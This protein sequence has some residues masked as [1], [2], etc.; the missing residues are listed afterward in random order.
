MIGLHDS[1]PARTDISRVPYLPGL[2]G[3]RALAV[4]AVMIYHANHEWLGGGFL[5]VE[6]F[7]VI[8]GYLITLLLVGEHERSGRIALKD[9]WFRRFRR[10]LPALFVMMSALAVYMSLFHRR[11]Q[12][13][14]RGDFLGGIFYGSNWYQIAVGQGYTA[15][16]A[17]APLRHLWSLAVEE[18]FYLVW[19][20]VMIL[21]LRRGARHLPRIG[22]WLF[23]VSVTIAIVTGALFGGGDVATTCAPGRMNGYWQIAGRC[24]STNESLYLSTITRAGGLMLGAAFAMVWRPGAIVRGP[25]RDKGRQVDLLAGAGVAILALL[26]W[27]LR[28]TTPGHDFG[29]R[30]DPWL[31]RGGFF[32]TGLAT[33]FI[34]AAAS[35]QRAATGTLLGNPVFV[36]IGTR[37]YGMYLYHWPIY[38]IIR[39]QAG[40]PLSIAQFVLAIAITVPITEAS[41]RYIETPIRKGRLSALYGRASRAASID[42]EARRNITIVLV[43]SLVLVGTAAISFAAADNVCVG[44]VACS[45]VGSAAD[46]T[47]TTAAPTQTTVPDVIDPTGT[48]T[49]VPPTAAPTTTVDLD[50]LPP[51]AIGESVMK[52]AEGALLAG[53]FVVDAQESRQGPEMVTELQNLRA[54][55]QLG[56]IVV[57]Q[58]GTN[59]TVDDLTFDQMMASLPADLTPSVVFLTVRAKDAAWIDGN[60]TR[61]RALAGRY[62]N[63]TI[64]DWAT[65]AEGVELCDDG[66]HSS[67]HGAAPIRTFTDMIF[68]AIGHPEL[69]PATTTPTS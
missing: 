63:V 47:T 5:G 55:N 4:V 8:S 22:L 52:G 20:L 15:A 28:L 3:L 49:T 29:I 45:L 46:T 58:I 68:D 10:L 39:E 31:F 65:V 35:H 25:M 14:T 44:D 50:A 2:D 21:L 48:A 12:G 17:F 43:S 42:R 6:V 11:P 7:F 16:E 60:N 56:R 59:G 54:N 32:L 33:V 9:F 41:Y 53:G 66:A 69:K 34:I 51:I 61:I 19:P 37:S 38:Q 18:Q 24:I 36:W 57:I 13:Q 26:M 23:G 27:R 62:T 64:A 40:R 30:F 67:C 1:T